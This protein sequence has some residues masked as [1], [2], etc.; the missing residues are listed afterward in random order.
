MALPVSKET[1]CKTYLKS[2]NNVIPEQRVILHRT[3]IVHGVQGFCS[4]FLSW[5]LIST[6][7]LSET[8]SGK[9]EYRMLIWFT[10]DK[11]RA[12]F[13]LNMRQIKWQTYCA[14]CSGIVWNIPIAY[15]LGRLGVCTKRPPSRIYTKFVVRVVLHTGIFQ[16]CKHKN[17]SSVLDTD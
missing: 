12:L 14:C 6:D 8:K 5:V 16:I 17:D 3:E 10:N 15:R 11:W 9:D 4:R 2:K 13:V 1:G 7:I